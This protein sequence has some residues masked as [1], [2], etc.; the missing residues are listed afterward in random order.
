MPED[1][2][3]EQLGVSHSKSEVHEAIKDIDK[4]LYPDAFCKI[5]PDVTRDP[6]Y[7]SVFHSDSAGT[8]TSL[9]YIM[10]KETEELKWFR[11]VVRDAIVMNVDDVLCV[12]VDGNALIS[13]TIG[14]NKKL[15]NGEILN[16][17]IDEH[18]KFTKQLTDWGFDVTLAGGETEDVGDLIKTF[19]VAVSL[20]SRV[21]REKIIAGDKIEKGDSI[22]GFSSF[23]KTDYEEK[24]NSGIGSN[25]L[26]LARHGTLDHKYYKKYPECYD[27]HLDES[28]VFFGKHDLLE[29]LSGTD[30]MIGEA[31]LS[32][33]RTYTPVLTKV[34]E[35]YRNQIHAIFHNTGGGQTKCLNFGKGLKYIKNSLFQIPP[36]FKLIQDSSNTTWKEM[37]QVFNMGHRMELVVPDE[38]CNSIIHIANQFGVKAKKIGYIASNDA[39]SRQNEVLIESECG[40]YNYSRSIF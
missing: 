23:G 36:I 18:V 33:T 16:V 1:N 21:L 37:Y 28:L 8:K 14:R 20:F 34:L 30:L 24:Y 3:Y 17:L 2:K 15:I 27:S 32:P 6:K 39:N 7:C 29:K 5:L 19:E 13:D 10:Y 12:G 25:G 35:K 22:V 38:L 31:L 40:T 4:G 11:G 26:T 9:A